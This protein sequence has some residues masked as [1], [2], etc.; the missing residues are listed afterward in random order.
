MFIEFT[1]SAAELCEAP[2]IVQTCDNLI[3]TKN[4]QAKF[5]YV[6]NVERILL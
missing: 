3:G 1:D 2:F 4:S 6:E 5:T